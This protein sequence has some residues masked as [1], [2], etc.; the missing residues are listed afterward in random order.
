MIET[1]SSSAVED[2]IVPVRE[3]FELQE[4]PRMDAEERA[5]LDAVRQS[6]GSPAVDHT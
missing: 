3:I 2:R 1:Q 6:A 4:V 5:I